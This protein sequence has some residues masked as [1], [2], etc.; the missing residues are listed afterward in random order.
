M[1]YL[2]H[3]GT[4]TL[5]GCDNVVDETVNILKLP[6]HQASLVI[7]RARLS[8][9]QTPDDFLSRQMTML[10][11][12]SRHFLSS[13]PVPVML[14]DIP[15]LELSCSFEKQNVKIYQQLLCTRQEPVLMVMTFTRLA[16]L[17]EAATRWW[18]QVKTSFTA[19]QA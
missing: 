11:K 14:G 9:G 15:A 4:L 7:S 17:D 5:P 13:D 2:T 12:D 6:E 19:R 18:Q 3:E 10:K 8:N 16:P 1:N